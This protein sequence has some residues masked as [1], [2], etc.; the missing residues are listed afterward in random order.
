MPDWVYGR[1][2]MARAG[3][4]E[5]WGS[6]ELPDRLYLTRSQP[7]KTL[8]PRPSRAVAAG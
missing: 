2:G 4:G 3:S 6:G 1:T 5:G 8:C 7:P